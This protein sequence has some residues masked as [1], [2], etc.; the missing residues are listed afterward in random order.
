MSYTCHSEPAF[1]NIHKSIQNFDEHLLI[2]YIGYCLHINYSYGVAKYGIV[3]ANFI[4]T[5]FGC[6]TLFRWRKFLLS[7]RSVRETLNCAYSWRWHAN[8][9]SQWFFT[10]LTSVLTS[11]IRLCPAAYSSMWSHLQR[12]I[13]DDILSIRFPSL[14]ASIPSSWRVIGQWPLCH[15]MCESGYLCECAH[16]KPCH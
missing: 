10:N 9:Q 16:I 8:S 7:F 3:L 5:H 4:F 13:A 1:W 11:F 12:C 14:F 15:V 2:N 6:N